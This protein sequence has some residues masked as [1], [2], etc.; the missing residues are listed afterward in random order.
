MDDSVGLIKLFSGVATPRG[1]NGNTMQLSREWG[2][3]VRDGGG[4]RFQH[5]FILFSSRVFPLL[6]LR[7]STRSRKYH[8]L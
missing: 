5:R 8:C 6:S 2:A 7:N 1:S 3:G 4:R